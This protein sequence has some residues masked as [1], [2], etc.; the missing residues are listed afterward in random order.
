MDLDCGGS[1]RVRQ[2]R[3]KGWSPRRRG[4]GT[5]S[6]GEKMNEDAKEMNAKRQTLSDTEWVTEGVLL[7]LAL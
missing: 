6:T 3:V 5:G 1:R 4:Q 7:T 2:S